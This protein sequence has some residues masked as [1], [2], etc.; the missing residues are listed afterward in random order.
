MELGPGDVVCSSPGPEGAREVTNGTESTV[1]V[2]ILSTRH[3]PPVAVYPDGGEI[4]VWPGGD[5]AG[6]V[7]RRGSAVDCGDGEA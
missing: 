2:P 4:G 7:V 6:I 3:S 1:R 5:H